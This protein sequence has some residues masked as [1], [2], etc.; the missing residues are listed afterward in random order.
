M[1]R[2]ARQSATAASRSRTNRA[3]GAELS[4]LLQNERRQATT[5]RDWMSEMI[6]FK[7]YFLYVHDMDERTK[8]VMIRD[9]Q[10]PSSNS[11]GKWPQLRSNS[12]GKSPFI[13]EHHSHH[14]R[15]Q[16][17]APAGATK[18]QEPAKAKL[19]ALTASA[20]TVGQRKQP[21][22]ENPNPPVTT[23]EPRDLDVNNASQQF[24][25]LP[26]VIP[27]GGKNEED[28]KKMPAPPKRAG[29]TDQLPMYFGSAQASIRKLPRF[30]QGEPVASGVQAS[31]VTSAVRSQMI[32]STAIAPGAK[33]GSTREMNALKRRVLERNGSQAQ[34]AQ[35]QV[36]AEGTTTGNKR[37][38][39]NEIAE[40]DDDDEDEEALATRAGGRAPRKK[41]VVEKEP[42][43]GYCENCHDKFEDFDEVCLVRLELKHELTC[44]STLN[45]RC[46]A[47][48]RWTQA[49]LRIWI[50]S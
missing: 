36:A 35:A 34:Q 8:P 44:C 47:S 48:L 15:R 9:Y 29:S 32:S 14:P 1:Q 27:N 16:T 26:T 30:V 20:V 5:D 13:E 38:T 17:T 46:I 42:K 49:T 41:R 45:P 7:G 10:K 6:S 33:G 50:I 40:E 28:T 22:V 3:G 23:G 18:A 37:K 39:L 24:A 25:N 43:P 31:N 11:Q 19:R 12:M 2:E 4:Q 21:L